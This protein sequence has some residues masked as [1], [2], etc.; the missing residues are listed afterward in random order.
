MK[1]LELQSQEQSQIAKKEW[2][3][4]EMEE[5]NVNGGTPVGFEAASSASK[6]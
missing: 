5:L 1:D 3:K 4:P 6:S 2:I